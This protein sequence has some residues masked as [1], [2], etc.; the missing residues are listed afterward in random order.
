MLESGY[1]DSHFSN[2]LLILKRIVM[3]SKLELSKSSY[4]FF[5]LTVL[6]RHSNIFNDSLNNDYLTQN[7]SVQ[8][9]LVGLPEAFSVSMMVNIIEKLVK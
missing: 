3:N 2:F 1:A 7:L 8:V 4:I 6:F 5:A 9:N